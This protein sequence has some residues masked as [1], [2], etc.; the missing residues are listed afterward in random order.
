MAIP[1]QAQYDGGTGEPNDPYL[2]RTAEQMNAIGANPADWGKHFRLT[3]DIDLSAYAGTSFNLIGNATTPF[4]GVFDGNGRSIAHFNYTDDNRDDVGLFGH[5]SGPE[6]QVRDLM[7]IDPNVSARTRL[8]VGSIV[9]YLAAGRIVGCKVAGGVVRGGQNV[10]GLVGRHQASRMRSLLIAAASSDPAI[11]ISA[12]PEPAVQNCRF[13]GSVSGERRVGGMIGEC[14][15]SSLSGCCVEGTVSGKVEIG[16][17]AGRNNARIANCYAIADTTG[18]DRVGGLVGAGNSAGVIENCYAAGRVAGSDPNTGGLVG[19][20]DTQ[21]PVFMSFWDTQTS[22]RTTS[23]GGKGRGTAQMQ[24]ADTFLA[25][26]ACDNDGIWSIDDGKDYPRLSWENRPGRTVATLRLSDFVTGTGEPNDPFVIATAEAL[27]AVGMFPCEWNK[28]FVLGADLDLSVYTGDQ[29]NTIGNGLVPFTG[30]FDGRGHTIANFTYTSQYGNGVGLFGDVSGFAPAIRNVTL[31]DPNVVSVAGSYTGA[32][33]GYSFGGVLIHC[34]TQ[35]GRVCGE[36]DVG[37][38]AGYCWDGEIIDCQAVGEV[39]GVEHVG[40]LAGMSWGCRATNCRT[41]GTVTGNHKVG[42]L[43]GFH[44]SGTITDCS[45]TGEVSGNRAV[46]GLVG[47]HW[48]DTMSDCSSAGKVIGV[49]RVG[50]LVGTCDGILTGCH[51]S[52]DVRGDWYVGGLVGYVPWLSGAVTNCYATGNVAGGVCIGG[53]VGRNYTTII[54]CYATGDASGT[55]YVGGLTG[56]N[57]GSVTNCYAT[58]SV[59]GQEYVGGLTSVNSGSISY[60]YSTGRVT[61]NS[62]IGGLL[63]DNSGSV[64]ESFWDVETSGLFSSGAGKGVKTAELQTGATFLFWGAC[65]N[66][67]VWMIQESHDYPRLAWEGRPGE[68]IATTSLSDFLPGSGTKDDP[69]LIATAAELH[70]VSLFPCDWDKHFRLT[71]DIDL[72]AYKYAPFSIGTIDEPFRGVFDGDGHVITHFRRQLDILDDT[73]DV[74]LFGRVSGPSAEIRNMGMVAP[75]VQGSYDGT[76]GSLVGMLEEGI[77]DECWATDVRIETGESV[78]GLV[79]AN[80]GV[81]RNCYSTGNVSSGTCAGGLVG[82]NSGIVVACY[83]STKVYGFEDAGGLAGSN[84]PYWVG[85]PA[86]IVNCYATGVV[87]GSRAVGGL[88]GRAGQKEWGELFVGSISSCYATG[89]VSGGSDSGGLVGVLDGGSVELSF[90]DMDASGMTVSAGGTGKTTAEMKDPATFATAGWDFCGLPDGPHNVWASQEGYPLLWWQLSPA[91][92]LPAFS[93]GTGEPNDPYLLSTA[94]DLNRIGHNPLLMNAH[95]ALLAD[96]DLTGVAF[97]PIGSDLFPFTGTLDGCGKIITGFAHEA[98]DSN[99]VGLFAYVDG[100]AAAVRNVSLIA[101]QVTADAS[102]YVGSLVG[103]LRKGT[104]DNCHAENVVVSGESVTGGLVGYNGIGIVRTCSS[105]G[106]VSGAVDVG[107]LAGYNGRSLERCWSAGDVLGQDSVGGLVGENWFGQITDCYS[108]ATATGE[109]RVG[110]LVGLTYRGIA[111]CYAAGRVVG[112][113]DAGGLAGKSYATAI[114]S[115]WDIQTT[116]QASS[117]CG[118]G[119]TTA[120]MMTAATFLG[121]GWDLVGETANGTADIWW[122]DEGRDYPRL[123]GRP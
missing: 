5:I 42:G 8:N 35:G 36:I 33:V 51:A 14:N 13:T 95:F 21:G 97:F 47:D 83:S 37:G 119:K 1:V 101:P 23:F 57:D 77:L 102:R 27:N 115:F 118:V 114:S 64:T 2:I 30:T 91:P 41:T 100:S 22:G 53:L 113:A 104:L 6:A 67:G 60:C 85:A 66:A 46:G 55:R 84:C 65:D 26:G 105:F 44:W 107:G 111:N 71:A 12:A 16:G 40:G 112:A 62:R 9:G 88:A 121:A 94:A 109:N 50:G 99:F 52:G 98:T 81:I 32:L 43:V 49:E 10:G 17:L 3:A 11:G 78:G 63:K 38:L 19:Y 120:E 31:A 117:G 106:T 73:G 29:F 116:G 103:Y 7:L 75:E 28:H 74:G 56:D 86:R 61:G 80:K 54:A 122:I 20:E 79:G 123:T 48:G 92:A 96:I 4:S 58:G 39:I 69:I 45:S 15:G 87:T 82:H 70:A 34:A 25:W 89:R 68:P 72:L 108:N 24:D 90:W 93:G 76:V 110:G 59:H 18:T